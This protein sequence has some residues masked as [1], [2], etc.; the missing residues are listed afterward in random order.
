MIAMARFISI[1]SRWHGEWKY[2]VKS[3]IK[4]NI[5]YVFK[6]TSLKLNV[7]SRK[8]TR[9][10][11]WQYGDSVIE[12]DFECWFFAEKILN[13]LIII[14]IN[15]LRLPLWPYV[16]KVSLVCKT[17]LLRACE[18]RSHNLFRSAEIIEVISFAL[19]SVSH[20]LENFSGFNDFLSTP[21]G[22]NLTRL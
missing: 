13:T 12:I 5:V 9:Y 6:D 3:N 14:I 10:S 17:K 11:E 7:R 22:R 16:E 21:N 19:H 20:V 2:V 18:I 15:N 4:Y 1:V 8:Y